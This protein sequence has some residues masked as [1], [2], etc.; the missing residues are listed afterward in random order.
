MSAVD[1]GVSLTAYE[2]VEPVCVE[3]VVTVPS[4]LIALNLIVAPLTEGDT[5]PVTWM[6]S[7][8]SSGRAAP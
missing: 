3:C 6:L 4:G 8:P 7:S 5:F 2:L 1:I